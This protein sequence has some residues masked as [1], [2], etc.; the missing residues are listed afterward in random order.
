VEVDG[1]S[2]R[3][4]G[5]PGGTVS[6]EKVSILALGKETGEGTRAGSQR[7]AKPSTFN[8]PS[9][10]LSCPKKIA[11]IPGKKKR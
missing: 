6:K 5:L 10:S 4:I 3:Y 9:A 7:E 8:Y 2:P 11:A 1:T